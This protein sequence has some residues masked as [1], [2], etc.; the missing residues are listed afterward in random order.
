MRYLYIVLALSI[1]QFVGSAANAQVVVDLS[2]NKKAF[3]RGEPII[4]TSKISNTTAETIALCKTTT[5]SLYSITY[6]KPADSLLWVVYPDANRAP[7][8]W[9]HKWITTSKPKVETCDDF[10]N[11][12]LIVKQNGVGLYSD[13]INN[14]LGTKSGYFYFEGK[15]KFTLPEGRYKYDAN[16]IFSDGQNSKVTYEFDI[17]APG[18][19]LINKLDSLNKRTDA[20]YFFR[21]SSIDV[22]NYNPTDPTSFHTYINA[23]SD[24]LIA[25]KALLYLRIQ[26]TGTRGDVTT[27][28]VSL[29]N[30][31]LYH[32]ADSQ[33]LI[34]L[35]NDLAKN[36]QFWK[37]DREI[38]STQI[39]TL[40]Q[41]LENRNYYFSQYFIEQMSIRLEFIEKYKWAH[42]IKYRKEDL[43]S[44]RIYAKPGR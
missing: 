3:L 37:Q 15:Y 7:D 41:S 8:V 17:V 26:M 27:E 36:F 16:L 38:V 4:I 12:K 42:F 18:S 21:N 6:A 2:E 11:Q 20:H 44:F 10:F 43:K 5:S 40:L 23:I 22:K 24:S 34:F 13:L 32:K 14:C 31:K 28:N 35:L 30:L 33:T 29:E 39:E 19:D 25:S 9:S 1:L